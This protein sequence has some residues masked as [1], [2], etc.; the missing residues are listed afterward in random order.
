MNIRYAAEQLLDLLFPTLCVGCAKPGGEVLCRQCLARLASSCDRHEFETP[1]T[2]VRS[3]TRVSGIRAAGIYRGEL[4]EMVLG[5]KSS[6]RP[7]GVPLARL[8]V[9]AAGNDP[10]YVAPDLIT[11]VPSERRKI[12]ERGYNPA[13]LLARKVAQLLGRPLANC[14]VKVRL[15]EDQDRLP[16]P[17]RWEN[18]EGAFNVRTGFRPS[19]P[20]LL[21]DD[22]LT[23]GATAAGCAGALLDSGAESVHAL[24]A[25]R[26]VL[27]SGL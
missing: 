24:V 1:G 25:A 12:I 3:E 21:I 5:L 16:A 26:A 22:V 11:Y 13:E 23:T 6:C 2:R 17:D 10:C 7:F 18:I 8:M 20:V 9:S 19:G 14:L 4:K 27:D 15:T